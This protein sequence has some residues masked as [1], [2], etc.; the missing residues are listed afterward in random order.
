[1]PLCF[2]ILSYPTCAVSFFISYILC[3]TVENITKILNIQERL[4]VLTLRGNPRDWTVWSMSTVPIYKVYR[5]SVPEVTFFPFLISQ[6][7]SQP[8]LSANRIQFLITSLASDFHT[9][10]LFRYHW[11]LEKVNSFRFLYNIFH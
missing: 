1:M 8:L 4:F 7:F 5:L 9:L 3:V 2:K 6:P 11:F 10:S